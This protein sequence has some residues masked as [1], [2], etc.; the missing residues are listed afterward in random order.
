MQLRVARWDL[1]LPADRTEDSLKLSDFLS[2]AFPYDADSIRST[3]IADLDHSRRAL[4]IATLVRAL[5]DL[6]GDALAGEFD[7]DDVKAWVSGAPELA[8]PGAD[9]VA[10]RVVTAEDTSQLYYAACDPARSFSWRFRGSTL[11]FEQFAATLHDGVLAQ[12]AVVSRAS[13]HPLQGLVTAYNFDATNGHAYF[14][15]LRTLDAEIPGALTEGLVAFNS[16]LFEHF[17]LRHLYCELPAFNQFLIE[18]LAETGLFDLVG[19]YPEHLFAHG[20]FQDLF[21]YRVTRGAWYERFGSWNLR[22]SDQ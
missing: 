22:R 18:G 16:H 7:W 11:S 4:L 19:R 3:P 12:F 20:H 14:A 17:P 13:G 2:L 1:H 6:S 10:L 9:R 5:P 15:Y 21:I 8:A